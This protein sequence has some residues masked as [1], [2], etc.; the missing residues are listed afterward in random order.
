MNLMTKNYNVLLKVSTKY[1][2]ND[3][4]LTRQFKFNFAVCYVREFLNT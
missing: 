1:G 2:S 3:V 4:Y